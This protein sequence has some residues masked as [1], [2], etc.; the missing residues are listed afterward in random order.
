[1]KLIKYLTIFLI[2]YSSLGYSQNSDQQITEEA[3]QYFALGDYYSSA[4]AYARLLNDTK[5]PPLEISYKYAES[6]RL[7]NAYKEASHWYLYVINHDTLKKFPESYYWHAIMEKQSGNYDNS[8]G[9]LNRYLSIDPNLQNIESAKNEIKSCEKAKWIVNDTLPVT[10]EHLGA[11]IN[12]PYSEFGAIQLSD[13]AIYFSSLRRIVNE[14]EGSIL[15]GV[16]VSKIYRAKMSIAGLSISKEF[17]N[18]INNAKSNN[19]NIAFNADKTKLFFS[20]CENNINKLKCEIWISEQN[21]GKWGKPVRL[22]R[23][24]NLPGYT[25]TQPNYVSGDEFDIL[26]FSSNRPNGFGGLDIWYSMVNQGKYSDPVNLGSNINTFGDEITP[27]Y[28]SEDSTLYFSS[29]THYGIGGFDIFSTKGGLNQWEQPKNMGVPINSTANDIYFTVNEIDNDGY[30]TSNRV[31]SFFIKDETC[32]N[33]IF[34]YEWDKNRP[35][36]TFK[37]DTLFLDT[38]NIVQRIKDILPLTLYFHNDEPDP[39]T[40]KTTTD[41]NYRTTLANYFA[42]KDIYSDEYAKGL[43]DEEADKARKDID[44]FFNDFVKKGFSD[45]EL[46]ANWL[47]IDLEHGNSAKI[48]IKGYTSPLH[49]AE[50]NMKLAMRR[51]SSLKNYISEYRNG[52]FKPYLNNNTAKGAKLELYD[53]PIG[54]TQANSLVSDNPNDIRNSVYSKAAA[55]E[56]RIQ[57]VMYESEKNTKID[58]TPNLA[59]AASEIKID[60]ISK[61]ESRQITVQIQNI[62]EKDIQLDSVVVSSKLTNLI[63]PKSIISKQASNFITFVFS[64]KIEDKVCNADIYFNNGN[65]KRIK[66]LLNFRK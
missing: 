7:Y 10:I 54:K 61:T 11:N 39:A 36:L 28:H 48:T 27:F 25:N 38:T 32:C 35:L 59:I 31:G 5:T 29:N 13:T 60:K 44:D 4:N 19:A 24:I 42:L 3:E 66:F 51:I 6:L 63:F 62:G 40:S 15:P 22:S 56:R 8:I 33:D 1:M 16:F 57:I 30:L 20:R 26:Y 37:Q 50:Y 2:A 9:Y 23:K 55:L 45:L 43:Q 58:S 49:T 18:I 65:R 34:Y 14:E 17:I 46:F 47:L 21:K 41:K 53:A 12:T 52:I 64:S